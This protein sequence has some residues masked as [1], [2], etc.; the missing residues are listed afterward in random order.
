[1]RLRAARTLAMESY[2]KAWATVCAGHT[3]PPRLLDQNGDGDHI[4]RDWLDRQI[5][6][7]YAVRGWDAAGRPDVTSPSP[8]AMGEGLG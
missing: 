2:E 8:I 7:Y 1:M 5:G 3:L 4:D 6:A